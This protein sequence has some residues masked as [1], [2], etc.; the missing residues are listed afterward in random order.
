MNFH[1]AINRL[2]EEDKEKLLKAITND[3]EKRNLATLEEIK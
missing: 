1:E 2:C 3:V